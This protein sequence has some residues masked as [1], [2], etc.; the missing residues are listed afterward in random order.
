M[1]FLGYSV[2]GAQLSNVVGV[3]LVGAD[4]C[5]FMG[6]TTQEL[7]TKWHFVGAF[8]PFSRNHNGDDKAQEPYWFT[9]TYAVSGKTFMAHM[10]DA[11]RLKYALLPYY[12][13]QLSKIS[14]EGGTL[15]RAPFFSFPSDPLAYQNTTNNF[16]LGDALKVSIQSKD[17]LT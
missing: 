13:T 4:I 9:E 8:Y 2:T 6:P 17:N 5:G 7:C 12:Y 16:M 15:F 14:R 3:P 1:S 11:I 10:S